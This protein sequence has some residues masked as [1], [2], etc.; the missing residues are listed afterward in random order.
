M[1]WLNE[2]KKLG[3]ATL[4]VSIILW[5]LAGLKKA[6]SFLLSNLHLHR[7]GV[8]RYTKYR[9]LRALAKAGLVTI[10]DRGK[11][12]PTVNIVTG[13]CDAR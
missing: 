10:K 2:A 3:A 9:A 4:W 5:H 11:R 6:N 8:D 13:S 1:D 7:W 12:S